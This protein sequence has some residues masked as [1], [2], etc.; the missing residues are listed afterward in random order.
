M[1][2]QR[3]LSWDA[4]LVSR[5][6]NI[7]LKARV[8]GDAAQDVAVDNQISDVDLLYS[9]VSHLRGVCLTDLVWI[10]SLR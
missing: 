9:G 8:V 1:H 3:S 5:D 4:I 7:R 6:I 2:I 10:I